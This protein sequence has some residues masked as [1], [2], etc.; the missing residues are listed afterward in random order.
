V[1]YWL[2]RGIAGVCNAMNALVS[3][4]PR[5]TPRRLASLYRDVEIHCEPIGGRGGWHPE[6]NLLERLRT[7]SQ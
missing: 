5:I 7:E 6:E 1:P 4:V 3:R 2:M